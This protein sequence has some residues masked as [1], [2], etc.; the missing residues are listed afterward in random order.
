MCR[1]MEAMYPGGS[2]LVEA[3]VGASPSLFASWE[4]FDIPSADAT[5]DFA[6]TEIHVGSFRMGLGD[7]CCP[8]AM[9]VEPNGGNRW[10]GR[11]M[12]VRFAEHFVSVEGD[13]DQA[14]VKWQMLSVVL[15]FAS[16]LY[17]SAVMYSVASGRTSVEQLVSLVVFV[18][19]P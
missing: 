13:A 19:V 4:S 18:I 9:L 12:A 7:P 15:G 1:K 14:A 17:L 16:L 11:K 5:L 8:V 2:K 3:L 6:S 10:S